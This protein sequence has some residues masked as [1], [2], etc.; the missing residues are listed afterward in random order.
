MEETIETPEIDNKEQLVETKGDVIGFRGG[1]P[2]NLDRE[3]KDGTILRSKL[4][5]EIGTILEQELQNQQAR[6]DKIPIWNRMYRGEREDR[7]EGRAN[8]ATPIPRILT[9]A[10][11]VR[12]SEGL[13]NQPEPFTATPVIDP[14]ATPEENEMWEKI[15]VELENDVN[16]WAKDINLREKLFDPIM[17]SVKIG[18]GII[19]IWPKTKKRTV[20]R[21]ATKKEIQNKELHTFKLG[22]GEQGI[23]IV[24]TESQQPDVF[25]ISR[26]DWVQSSNSPNLQD[27]KLC[28]Y[29]TR[30]AQSGVDLKV[31]QGQWD[32]V[33]TKRLVAGDAVDE[34]KKARAETQNLEIP[35]HISTEFDVWQ[36]CYRFD[37][38]EDGEEDDIIIWYNRESKALVSCI[39]NPVFAGFRPFIDFIYN[40]NE[41]A[42]EGEGTMTI[43]EKP[44]EEIDTMHNQAIDRISQINGPIL[45]IREN[46]RGLEKFTAKPRGIYWVDENPE[47]IMKEFRF[48]DTTMSTIQEEQHLIDLCMQALGVTLDIL[49]QQTTDRPVFKE[50]AS[51]QAEANKKF[52][53]INRHYRSRIEKIGMMYLE[54]SA[55]YQ[56]THSYTVKNGQAQ[57]QRTINYPLEYLRDRIKVKLSGSTEV[58]N[59]ETRRAAAMEQYQVLSQYY[60]QLT[61]MVQAIVSP[62]AP[63]EF[64]KWVIEVSKRT[65]KRMEMIFKNMDVA[66]PEDAVLSIDDVV[67]VEALMKPPMPPPGMGGQGGPQGPPQGPPGMG[68]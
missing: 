52:R 21:Y 17:Q 65:E 23:K 9:D 11:F 43:L 44:V 12:V 63:P 28:G 45:L 38:D 56:P 49:G 42:S 66:N 25:G 39:Y 4:R 55:Q 3:M 32:E 14:E 8:V 33:E 47:E 64:K 48:S 13:D 22:D 29:K 60:T 2:V 50:M 16:W 46:V 26:E 37:V 5:N 57:E 68:Q 15:A 27:A 31:T 30:Y 20:V 67:D 62:M 36:L 35:D 24:T 6:I 54:I 40:Q 61:G 41:Y 51:R 59:K 1:L 18:K 7:G 58:E 53:Y 10:I 19:M 34:V